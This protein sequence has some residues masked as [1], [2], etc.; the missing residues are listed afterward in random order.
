MVPIAVFAGHGLAELQ[1]WLAGRLAHSRRLDPRLTRRPAALAAGLVAALFLTASGGL[2]AGRNIAR[3]SMSAPDGPVVS[4]HEAE[5][6]RVLGTLVPPGQRVLNDR[7]DGSVWMYAIAGVLPVAGHYNASQI[8][9]DARLLS[10]RFN[11]YA[12][13]PEVRAAVD[14]IG[15][16]VRDARPGLRP[17]GATG[18][19]AG[20]CWLDQMPLAHREVPEPGRGDLPDPDAAAGPALTGR[21]LSSPAMGR[22]GVDAAGAAAQPPA[23]PTIRGRTGPAWRVPSGPGWPAR[24]VG[25]GDGRGGRRDRRAALSVQLS[26]SIVVDPMDRV[27]QVSGVAGLDLRFL[28]L[29]L[30]VLGGCLV[31]GRRGGPAWP[32]VRR[33]RLRRHR[34]A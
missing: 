31:A 24:A 33:L 34:R 15:V 4:A 13:D 27:G 16:T 6:M 25:A 10:R 14:R 23:R 17:Q 29:A 7:G 12:T 1:R 21:R 19:S 2:Y 5:A 28:L 9:P 30:V 3:M 22:E 18:A 26:R 32:L 11:Q 8:G 20:T